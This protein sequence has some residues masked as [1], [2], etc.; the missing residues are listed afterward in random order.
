M[1]RFS[2]RDVL[3]A[4]AA[5]LALPVVLKSLPAAA[6][7]VMPRKKFIGVFFP[8]GAYMP[9]AADGNWNFAE[10][11]K[12]LVTAGFQQ[13]AVIVRGLHQTFPGVDPHWQ[14][15]AGFL[16][17]N[18]ILLGT[19]GLT[20]CGKS[21]D[22]YVAELTPTPIRSLEIG[23]PY[24]H[25]HPLTDHPGYSDDYLN[26][27]SWQADDK[28]RAPI[29]DP[30]AMFEKLFAR[31][32]GGVAALR[33]QLAKKKS[34]LDHLSKDATRV[35]AKL[36]LEQRGVL[37]AY[38]ETVRDVEREVTA[39]GPSMCTPTLTSPT[40]DFSGPE[41]NYVRRYQLMNQMVVLAMQCGLTNAATFMYGPS[42]SFITFAEVFGSGINHHTAAHNQ[43]Q[44]NLIGR[45]R[46]ILEM[47]MGL[48]AD[49][50]TRLNAANL[51]D[52]TLVL[53]GSDMSDGDAHNT[54]NL[55][56]VLCG[57]GPD[58]KWGQEIATSGAPLSNLHLEVLRLYGMSGLTSFGSGVMASTG[59]ATGIRV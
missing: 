46:Q 33:H 30:K 38:L 4:L 39:A 3:G 51:L 32:A 10:A 5:Q 34:V 22:Q 55:P 31:D 21:V 26:R 47:E 12:P 11:L 58:V 23:A 49:L 16:S 43:G 8:N 36:P 37:D 35:S 18:P 2:R 40:E 27:I 52:E 53:A 20:R 42:S 41:R 50:L 44:A 13:N 6:Q 57:K 54:R 48:L 17:C 25:I 19:P 28:S 29:P 9:G 1:S 15:T 56:I 7:V 14:N 59:S 24:Y 45:V